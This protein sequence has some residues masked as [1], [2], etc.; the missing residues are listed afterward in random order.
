MFKG[1]SLK[2]ILFKEFFRAILDS[3]GTIKNY[4][5]TMK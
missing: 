3:I 2:F 4:L 1:F 5:V